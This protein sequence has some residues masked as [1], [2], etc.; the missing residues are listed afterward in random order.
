MPF[1]PNPENQLIRLTKDKST[2][3]LIREDIKD[4]LVDYIEKN[5]DLIIEY[6]DE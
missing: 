6:L 4:K 2:T 5:K 3:S 1:I